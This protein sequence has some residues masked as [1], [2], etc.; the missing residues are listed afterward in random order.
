MRDIRD[1]INVTDTLNTES[2]SE[3]SVFHA[4]IITIAGV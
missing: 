3:F 4:C 1:F 2:A